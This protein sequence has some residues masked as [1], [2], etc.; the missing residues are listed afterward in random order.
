MWGLFKK[1]K[2]ENEFVAL[3]KFD[4]ARYASSID[5]LF[6]EMDSATRAHILVAY[7]NLLPV[8]SIMYSEARKK[9]EDFSLDDFIPE[10]V[11]KMQASAGDEVN[12]RRFAWF[13]F[14]AL[15]GRL[16]KLSKIDN[17]ALEVGAKI[18]CLL[19]EDAVFLKRLL[20]NN[21]VW[22]PEEKEWFDLA[23]PD[24]KLVEW[25]INFAMPPMFAEH[26]FVRD[27]AQEKQLFLSSFKKRI[28]FMP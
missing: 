15:L 10:V 26:R 23:Q 16:E 28:G 1:R 20:P 12:S 19:S 8:V 24:E 17:T 6:S 18:W 9:G 14:A 7:E 21:I 22:K 25:V 3:L 11:A 4:A 5:H 13:L 2:P 27:F